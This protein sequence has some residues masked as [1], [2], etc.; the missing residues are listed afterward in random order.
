LNIELLDRL[1]AAS[2]EFV[3]IAEL[4]ADPEAVR[5]DLNALEAFGFAI[6]WHPFGGVA[7]R[8]SPDRLCP[9]QIEWNLGTRLIGRRIAVWNRVASTNDLAA[10]ASSSLAND[11][12]V[13]LAEEQSAG[14]G[15]RGRAWTVPPSSSI[16]MSVLLF[17]PAPLE[18]PAWLTALAAVSVADVVAMGDG[19]LDRSAGRPSPKIKWPNDVRVAG[20]KVAG[21]L[22]ERGQGTVI[23]IG[24][25]VNVE[26]S[27]FPDD[28]H[29]SATSLQV[30]HGR[31]LDRSE[32]VRNLIRR[33]D[34]YYD[35]SITYGPDWLNGRYGHYSEHRG[36]LV[37]VQVGPEL[38]RGR[39]VDLDLRTGLLLG[40]NDGGAARIA[41][42]EIGA[43]ANR[44]GS[45]P[46]DEADRQAWWEG[47]APRSLAGD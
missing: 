13:I 31:R 12:L 47:P 46:W 34:H 22:V 7:Y 39:L 8:G 5:L 16:L 38:R 10:S 18:D 29:D 2:G 4:G 9:D 11:G 14:R 1:R 43:I 26:R 28:L 45:E 20:R 42:R 17:P 32:V 41:T 21:I 40:L 36:H 3:P 25:N 15:S 6:E 44:A 30:L 19:D 24:L 37:E 33:L 23:G 27:D 35:Q